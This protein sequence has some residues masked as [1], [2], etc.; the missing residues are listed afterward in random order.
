MR[1]YTLAF[2]DLRSAESSTESL[3]PEEVLL[4]SGEEKFCWLS[5]VLQ[6]IKQCLQ[7]C[8]LRKIVWGG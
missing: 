2:T 8:V 7:H 5:E 3:S 4:G 6:P 1:T